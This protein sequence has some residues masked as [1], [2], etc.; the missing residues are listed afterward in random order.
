MIHTRGL[1]RQFRV[2][3][4]TVEAVRGIDLDVTGGELVA[5]LGPNGAGK[6]TM[7]RMLTTLLR[8]T[9][10]TAEVA[11]HDVVAHPAEVRRHIGSIGQGNGAGHTQRVR[12]ELVN[13]GRCYGLDRR[14]AVVR[15]GELLDSLGLGE[16]ATRVVSTLSGGQRRR[17][18]IALGMVHRP[19]L[20]FLDEPSTGLDPQNR[21]NLKEHVER[22]R[23]EHGTTIVLTTHYLDEADALADRVVVID[24]GLVIAD[25]SPARLKEDLV[26]DRLALT[27]VDASDAAKVAAVFEQHD[28]VRSV[29]VDGPDV[30]AQVRGGAALLPA[31]LRTLD[32]AGLAVA[33]AELSRATLDD[34]FLA[35]TGRS[36]RESALAASTP[37]STTP[38]SPLPRPLGPNLEEQLS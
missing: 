17:L 10:G 3:D 18:D 7:L 26:G 38:S 13:Q 28:E 6:S 35:L 5:L 4:G 29:V 23:A 2:K 20:L 36:L 19:R 30:T 37:P 1:T 11:G 15:A 31:L 9:A 32:G 22:L 34:V 12:D 33:T 25:G 8:P 27:V 14:A 21:A 24:H 16:L